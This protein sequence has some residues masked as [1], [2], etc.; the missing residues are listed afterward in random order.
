M[1]ILGSNFHL[2]KSLGGWFRPLAG[3]APYNKGAVDAAKAE[4]HAQA[5]LLEAALQT[6][7]FLVGDRITLADIIVASFLGRGFEFVSRV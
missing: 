4:V 7:T 1:R 2:L 6:R 3:K 5:A